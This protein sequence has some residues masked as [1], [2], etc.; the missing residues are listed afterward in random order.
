M[1]KSNRFFLF[2][3]FI[4][5][6]NFNCYSSE[7]ITFID[8]DFLFKNS[9]IGKKITSNIET[10]N[11]EQLKILDEKKKI[12]IDQENKLNK[13]KNII[14][15]DEFSEN[16]NLFKKNVD[17]Y[18][19]EKDEIFKKL[20]IKKKEELEFFFKKINPILENY[21]K[22]NSVSLILD[23]KNIFIGRQNIDITNSILDIM[24]K[25]IN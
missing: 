1:K 18:N 25:E 20:E 21:M 9:N 8:I 11:S 10:Y 6:Y 17:Q 23:K 7:K 16:Y 4:F 19:K 14:S 24:N 3:F 12:I 15:K 22:Q 5:L 13:T 2:L